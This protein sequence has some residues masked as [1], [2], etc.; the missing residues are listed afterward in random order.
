[1][2]NA[3]TTDPKFNPDYNTK[4]EVELVYDNPKSGENEYGTYYLYKLKI[5]DVTHS[6]FASQDTHSKLCKYR[7]GDRVVI[8]KVYDNENKE[9]KFILIEN[10]KYSKEGQSKME[11]ETFQHLDTKANFK[12]ESE[13]VKDLSTKAMLDALEDSLY[14]EEQLGRKINVEQIAISLFNYRDKDV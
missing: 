5:D 9:T 11:A 10:R 8:Q 4:T 13:T 6:F 1:M 3:K 12:Q 2:N 7:S 14:I